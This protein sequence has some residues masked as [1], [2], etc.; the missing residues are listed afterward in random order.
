M[1]A[2]IAPILCVAALFVVAALALWR[3]SPGLLIV[4][5]LAIC[6]VALS[7]SRCAGDVVPPRP[8][9][10]P[11]PPPPPRPAPR[12]APPPNG[13]DCNTGHHTGR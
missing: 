11:A 5:A 1:T 7:V 4:G 6:L 10:R 9:P 13:G 8:A 3:D 12:P 2:T